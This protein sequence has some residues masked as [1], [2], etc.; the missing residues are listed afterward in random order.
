LFGLIRGTLARGSLAARYG[1][2]A[3]PLALVIALVWVVHPLQTQA[4]TYIIQRHESLMGMF[5]LAAL[6][7]FMR[8]QTSARPGL[9]YAASVLACVLGMGVKEVMVTAPILVLW[10]DRAMV[11]GSWREI[12]ARRKFYYLALF[13]TWAALAVPLLHLQSVVASS[14][15]AG[16]I[17]SGVA[18]AGR[19]SDVG[20]DDVGVVKGLT[21]AT[22]LLSEAGVLLHYLRLCFWPQGL[23]FDYRWPPVQSFGEAVGPGLVIL[24]LLGLTIWCIFRHKEWSL[25]GAWFFL[26]LAPTSSILPILDL[27]AEHRMY[28]PLAAVVTA[29]TLAAYAG[30][31]KLADA[32]W[33]SDQAARKLGVCAAAAIVVALAATTYARNE[34]YRTPVL[35]WQDTAE[36]VPS[37]FRAH[38]NLGVFLARSGNIPDAIT[39]FQETLRLAPD[40]A[41]AYNNLGNALLKTNRAGDAVAYFQRAIELDHQ[42]AEAH[43]NLGNALFKAGKKREAIACFQRAVE[44]APNLG[45]AHNNLGAALAGEGKLPEAMAQFQEAARSD[46]E[47]AVKANINMGLAL[48]SSGKIDEAIAVSRRTCE[49]TEN[50]VPECLDALAAAYAAAGQYPEAI[51]AAQ[52]AV[53]LASASGETSMARQIEGRLAIYRRNRARRSP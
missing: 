20:G 24:I 33:F 18:E 49:L 46:P 21:P 15:N 8:A 27:A 1:A 5:Y 52:R 30:L 9:C 25:L 2:A 35:L 43:N 23:C 40:H 29:A 10:Y 17:A 11:A 45:E 12:F 32:G 41:R 36:K 14:G 38:F 26:I 28:L 3:V 44:L 53:Q 48:L 34:D 13:S 47:F 39:Q 22:Y 7:A 16:E 6:Y 19:A 51:S 42:L 31:K 37:N 50:R 4:V